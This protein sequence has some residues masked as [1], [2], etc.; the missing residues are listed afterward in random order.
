[1]IRYVLAVILTA[2]LLAIGM[3]G[4]DHA[5]TVR[6]EQQ[7]ETQVEEIESAVTEL[8]ETEAPTSPGR[9]GARRV[10]ELDLPDDDLTSKP[11]EVLRIRPDPGGVSIVEYRVDGRINRTEYVDAIIENSNDGSSEVTDLSGQ[12]GTVTLVLSLKREQ[13]DTARPSKVSIELE[14][15]SA[16]K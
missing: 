3:A 7:V 4:V 9:D 5:A 11:V 1:M 6:S 13:S 16:E 10:L 12:Q 15:R 8:V 2:A 14:V